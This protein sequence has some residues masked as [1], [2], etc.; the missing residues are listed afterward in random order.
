MHVDEEIRPEYWT[1]IRN[2]PER[3]AQAYFISTGKH[4]PGGKEPNRWRNNT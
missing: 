4:M 2:M 3:K 1:N